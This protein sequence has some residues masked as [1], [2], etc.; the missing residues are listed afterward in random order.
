[1]PLIRVELFDFRMNEET[2]AKLIAE[3]TAGCAGRLRRRCAS[4]P[5]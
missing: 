4:T 1:M 2:S 3:L 5:G